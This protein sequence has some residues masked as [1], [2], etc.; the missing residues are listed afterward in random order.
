MKSIKSAAFFL[1]FFFTFFLTSG[2]A[3]AATLSLSPSTGAFSVGSTFDVSISMDTNGKSVNALAIS[4][5]FPPDMLQVVSPSLGQ[6]V[7]GVWTSAPKFDNANGKISLQ[8]GIPGGITASDAL[9]ST[10]TFRVKSVGTAIVKF[11]DG[12]KVLLNDG[13]GTNALTQSTSAIYTLKLP[14]P[15]GPS[16]ASQTNPDQSEWYK[17]STVSFHERKIVKEFLEKTKKI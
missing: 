9:I 7:I 13:L 3:H 11:L 14:P 1:I 8:G 16:L 12:S 4:L 10:V 5:D 15:A 2:I 17:D 6:S